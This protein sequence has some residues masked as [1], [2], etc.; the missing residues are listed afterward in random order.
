MTWT[1]DTTWRINVYFGGGYGEPAYRLAEETVRA[2][3]DSVKSTAEALETLVREDLAS[4]LG[5]GGLAAELLS[6]SLSEVNWTE[7]ASTYISDLW[8]EWEEEARGLGRGCALSAASW[9][10]DGNADLHHARKVL[11][12]L[13]DG[14]PAADDYLPR[15][16]NLSGEWADD[17]TPQS[18]AEDITGLEDIDSDLVDRLAEA[19]EA[20]VSDTFESACEKQLRDTIGDP[21]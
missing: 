4:E 14:D 19:W 13:E 21:E 11:T 5:A 16:P 9:T 15:R 10:V 12:M 3:G 17:P 18:L 7:L 8:T 2:H 1:N 6:S 20:G